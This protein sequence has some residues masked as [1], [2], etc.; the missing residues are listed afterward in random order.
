[1]KTVLS[2]LLGLMLLTSLVGISYGTPIIQPTGE[3]NSCAG[4][5]P[6]NPN[7]ISLGCAG[8]AHQGGNENPRHGCVAPGGRISLDGGCCQTG[9]KA[10]T[11]C[12]STGITPHSFDVSDIQADTPYCGPP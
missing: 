12:C 10:D 1:M 6:N 9:Q 3:A 4:L 5:T 7:Y 11:R 2:I 8:A